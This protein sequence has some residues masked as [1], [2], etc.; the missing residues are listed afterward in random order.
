MKCI[1]ANQ[2]DLGD[3]SILMK[4]SYLEFAILKTLIGYTVGGGPE[5][6]T[7]TAKMFH[8]MNGHGLPTHIPHITPLNIK[9]ADDSKAHINAKGYD[10]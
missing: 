8:G 7:F 9:F 10:I 3:D 4:V 6:T 5:V 1:P 2:V